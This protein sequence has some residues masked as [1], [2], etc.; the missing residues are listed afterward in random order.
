MIEKSLPNAVPLLAL[1]ATII[2]IYG[3]WAYFPWWINNL[4]LTLFLVGFMYEIQP[5]IRMLL[6]NID[7]WL[8]P[9]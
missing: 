2:N 3:V 1:I 6:R 4:W 7:K 9:R 5:T 8:D